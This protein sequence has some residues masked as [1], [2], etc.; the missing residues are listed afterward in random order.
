MIGLDT[1]VL[2][3]WLVDERVWPDDAPHQ[4][5]LAAE[6]LGRRDMR[7]FVNA[8]VLV[9]TVW[10]LAQPLRQRKPMLVALVDRLLN[11]SNIVVDHCDAAKA[12]LAAWRDG[13]GEFA[14]HFIGAIN[15][16]AGCQ[17]T[18]TFDRK[19][20]FAPTFTHLHRAP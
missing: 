13:K 8:V 17:T 10:I 3:R 20:A 15:D 19:A 11:A 18:L 12:A 16:L 1:N 9:E 14:D 4:T 2:L 7:F 5:A 6:T